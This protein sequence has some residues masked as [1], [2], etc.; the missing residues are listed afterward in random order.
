MD[1][2]TLEIKFNDKLTQIY[3][4]ENIWFMIQH[5][6]SFLYMPSSTH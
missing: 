4:H 2:T 5:V 6:T 3:M 1:K